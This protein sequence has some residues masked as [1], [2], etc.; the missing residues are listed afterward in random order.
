MK[1]I[2][3]ISAI[4][5]LN[6]SRPQEATEALYQSG[7]DDIV[8]TGWTFFGCDEND[9]FHTGFQAKSP[10]GQRIEGVVCSGWFKGA[11]I[12]LK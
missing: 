8:I 11:T 5:I 6:C 7:Y 3:I 9:V 12:R 4:F 10:R 2:I 1:I